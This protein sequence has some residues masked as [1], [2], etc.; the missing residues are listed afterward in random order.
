MIRWCSLPIAT[1]W[2]F[3]LDV[4]KWDDPFFSHISISISLFHARWLCA[5]FWHHYLQTNVNQK[6]QTYFIFNSFFPLSHFSSFF[7]LSHSVLIF[8]CVFNAV[9]VGCLWEPVLEMRRRT[10]KHIKLKAS[11]IQNR[12]RER[13]VTNTYAMHISESNQQQTSMHSDSNSSSP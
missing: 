4:L 1:V 11:D 10:K 2:W 8:F 12:E 3:V 7:S 5:F 6:L 9:D 13:W